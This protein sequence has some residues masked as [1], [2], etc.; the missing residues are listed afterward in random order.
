MLLTDIHPNVRPFLL[1]ILSLVIVALLPNLVLAQQAT[2][3]DDAQT[4]TGNPNQNFG[5]KVSIQ[6]SGTTFKGFLK[7]NFTPNLPTGTTGSLIEKATLKLF[8]TA[9]NTAGAAEVYRVAGD[10]DEGSIT[11]NTA[12]ALGSLL[13]SLSFDAT[14]EARWVTVDITP[15]VKDW[16][17]NVLPNNGIALIAAPGGLNV[18]FNSKEN[19]TTSHEPV[20]EVLVNHVATADTRDH[21]GQRYQRR[22]RYHSR[23]GERSF[24]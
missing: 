5:S 13:T 16:L 23:F 3:T 12:P 20:L 22:P 6:V 17:D 11:N 1:V 7:F 21:G 24:R 14:S 2:L 15:L 19:G 8:V 4:S 18:T 10:W 9:V